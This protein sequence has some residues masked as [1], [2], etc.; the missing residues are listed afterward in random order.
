MPVSSRGGAFY[1][2]DALSATEVDTLTL[3]NC[4]TGDKGGAFSLINTI[5]K[6]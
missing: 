5:L 4:H 1:I 6:D 3:F 2:K